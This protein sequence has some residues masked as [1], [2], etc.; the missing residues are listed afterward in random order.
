MRLGEHPVPAATVGLMPCPAS[1]LFV[2]PLSGHPVS[3]SPKEVN[4]TAWVVPN[5]PGAEGLVGKWRVL[6]CRF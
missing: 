3:S 4:N 1:A 2:N 6:L 5:T